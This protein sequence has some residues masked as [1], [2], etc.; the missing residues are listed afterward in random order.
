M[1]KRTTMLFILYCTCR[2]VVLQEHVC[3]AMLLGPRADEQFTDSARAFYI[4]LS[5]ALTT[6]Q[7]QAPAYNGREDAHYTSI[8]THMFVCLLDTVRQDGGLALMLALILTEFTLYLGP[9]HKHLTL[10]SVFKIV[11]ILACVCLSAGGKN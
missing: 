2:I 8:R 4:L 10:A 6:T 9:F 11:F 5:L 1:V 7:A 3:C